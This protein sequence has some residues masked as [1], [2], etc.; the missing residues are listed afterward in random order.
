MT[1]QPTLYFTE[2]LNNEAEYQFE[3][4]NNEEQGYHYQDI[5]GP[6]YGPG[7]EEGYEYHSGALGLG[8]SQSPD[9]N[10]NTKH[11]LLHSEPPDVARKHKHGE[12]VGIA[13]G[14]KNDKKGKNRISET[15]SE[16]PGNISVETDL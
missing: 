11:I 16:G 5:Q 8:Q 7:R 6:N 14:T 2:W 13:I 3:R 4:G 15:G 10:K 1:E 9:I 12:F